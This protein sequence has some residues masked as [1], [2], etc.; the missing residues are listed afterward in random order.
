MAATRRSHAV[1]KQQKV[2][3]KKTAKDHVCPNKLLIGT[4]AIDLE[5]RKPRKKNNNIRFV[6]VPYPEVLNIAEDI[7]GSIQA[8]N[9]SSRFLE[10]YPMYE[11]ENMSMIEQ[12]IGKRFATRILTRAK[13]DSERRIIH[14]GVATMQHLRYSFERDVDFQ[15]WE[16]LET[17]LQTLQARGQQSH[18][19]ITRHA[20]ATQP[21]KSEISDLN[22]IFKA[23]ADIPSIIF[24][25]WDN[26]PGPPTADIY[27]AISTQQSLR[28][29]IFRCFPS[30][31]EALF[32][33][34]KLGDIRALNEI[35]TRSSPKYA[36]RPKTCFTHAQTRHDMKTCF[37]AGHNQIIMKRSHSSAG[38]HVELV[39]GDRASSSKYRNNRSTGYT[40]FGQ[41]YEPFFS[42]FGEFRVFIVAKRSPASTL[43]TSPS[44]SIR[45]R[46]GSIL[47]TVITCWPNGNDEPGEMYAHAASAID[48]R[49]PYIHPLTMND[50]HEFALY[51]YDSLRRRSDWKEHYESLEIG[52]RLDIGV[53]TSDE[54]E[55]GKGKEGKTKADD[56]GEKRFFVNEITRFYQADYFS[57]QTLGA[58][59]QLVCYA[60]AEAIDGYFGEDGTGVENLKDGR[61]VGVYGGNKCVIC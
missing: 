42:R 27:S 11:S 59:G 37:L 19:M 26:D 28:S 2:S 50:L 57:Q 30:Q 6:W 39:D 33:I 7:G 46:N 56:R 21:G 52:V 36:Y 14:Q 23:E 54:T 1:S 22:E 25:H 16:W 31:P 51:I 60:F 13:A 58:P 45:G 15:S 53:S 8:S 41:T 4:T 5:R 20:P 61:T 12:K 38:A 47:H 24:L 55:K 40:W 18:T 17:Q 49:S 9:L 44:H 48:F 32:E 35:A 10:Q 43:S 29:N 3:D 34:Q